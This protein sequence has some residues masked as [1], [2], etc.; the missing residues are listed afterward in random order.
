MSK[1]GADNQLTREELDRDDISDEETPHQATMASSDVI[2]RRK[3]AMPKRKMAFPSTLRGNTDESKTANAFSFLKKPQTEKTAA[4]ADDKPAKLKALNLQFKDKLEEFLNSDP[5]C[6][7]RPVFMKYGKYID[8]IN[9]S[10]SKTSVPEPKAFSFTPQSITETV[11][12]GFGKVSAP[13]ATTTPDVH[14]PKQTTFPFAPQAPKPEAAS[15]QE[16]SKSSFTFT[17][18]TTTVSDSKANADSSESD[19]EDE[20]EIKI[21][22]PTFSISTK[23]ITSDSVF[24]FGA[25]KKEQKK[26]DSDSE[27]DVEIKGPEFKFAGEVKSDVFKLHKKADENK[28]E[29]KTDNSKVTENKAPTFSFGS[30]PNPF[31]TSGSK[32]ENNSGSNEPAKQANTVPKP[33]FSFTNNLISK[34]SESSQEKK[35]LSFNFTAPKTDNNEVQEASESEKTKSSESSTF[36]FGNNTTTKTNPFSGNTSGF[37]FGK[38]A[39]TSNTT[40]SKPSISFSK[41]QNNDTVPKSAFSFGTSANTVTETNEEKD[42]NT[43]G[44]NEDSKPALNFNFSSNTSSQKPSFSFGSTS[45]KK[46]ETTEHSTT[47]GGFSFGQSKAPAF[48]FGTPATNTTT[49]NPPSSG[50]KFSLPFNQENKSNEADSSKISEKK[51]DGNSATVETTEEQSTSSSIQLQ[52][53]EEDETPLFTCRSKLMTINTKTNGYDSRG[54]GELKLLQ[55]KDDK[56]KIRLLCRSDG[57]GN[58]LLNTAVVKSFKYSPLTPEN[59]NLVKIPT[60]DKDGALVTYVAR[61]KQ[62]ADGRLFVKS[63]EDAKNDMN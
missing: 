49:N 61:F 25:A 59:E 5:A 39:S 60:I 58:I 40:E 51:E 3:I 10:T 27:S 21:T 7:L 24:A 18:P 22:G 13:R 50:F 42:S 63:I 41:P 15:S 44:G 62:K 29:T 33:A 26:D 56:S 28:N 47:S 46:E 45:E 20:K 57:M 36:S 16:P 30:T 1:R 53:G 6:D 48:S 38:P 14:T 31:N 23:P 17:K 2:S 4:N 35:P 34:E 55:K 19:S 43:N 8:E 37:S 52:N 12:P 9:S 54:V 11:A 32:D